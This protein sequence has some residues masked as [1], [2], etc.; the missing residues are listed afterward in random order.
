MLQAG[1]ENSKN[2][3]VKQKIQGNKNLILFSSGFTDKSSK[4][5]AA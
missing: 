1:T 2:G 4:I 3:V 5:S